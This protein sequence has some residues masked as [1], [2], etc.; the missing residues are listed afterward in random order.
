MLCFPR[1]LRLLSALLQSALLLSVFTVQ[2]LAPAVTCSQHASVSAVATHHHPGE[3]VAHRHTIPAAQN[4]VETRGAP[5]CRLEAPRAHEVLLQAVRQTAT[6]GATALERAFW[7]ER[8]L[9]W[10]AASS[11]QPFSPAVAPPPPRPAA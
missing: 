4:P 2:V 7:Q 5:E 8:P 11:L 3:V 6:A 10:A 9:L 1:R